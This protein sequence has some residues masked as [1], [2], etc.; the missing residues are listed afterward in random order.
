MAL[1]GNDSA[2]D[3]VIFLGAPE[4][5]VAVAEAVGALSASVGIERV[6]T[7]EQ[8]ERA[9]R[10]GMENMLLLSAGT[11]VVV[12]GY[13]LDRFAAGAVNFHPGSPGYPGRDPHHFAAY[14]QCGV[15]GATAHIMTER[16]DEGPILDVEEETVE[17][18][19]GPDAYLA[20]GNR[21][22]TRL[23]GRVIP[24]LVAGTVRTTPEFGWR[25]SKTT[26]RDFLALCRLD[27]LFDAQENVRR[28]RAVE[29]PGYANAHLDVA[30]Y[31]F[32]IE[33]PAP[34]RALTFQ[35]FE[36]DFTES[37]Y[38]DLLDQVTEQYRCIDF[39][40][41]WTAKKPCVLWRHDIDFSV[42][43][44][45]RL[46]RMEAERGLKATYFVMLGSR[47]Y[48]VF[49][50]TPLHLVREIILD[51]HHIGLHF[52]PSVLGD[53]A[54]S[55]ST[56]EERIVWEAGILERL[57]GEPVATVS[58]HNPD[59]TLSWLTLDRL[60]GMINT[61]GAALHERYSYVS[62]SNGIWRHRRLKDVVGQ[63]APPY[64]HVLTHPAWW[65]PEPMPARTRIRRTAEG[66]AQRTMQAYDEE[67]VRYGRPNVQ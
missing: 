9:T 64:L 3:L 52:D 34:P 25:G 14:D 66:R 48:N 29:M 1:T 59:P 7:Q 62:D 51:G 60:G 55:Q 16:V 57:T 67:L 12:P 38:G 37:A 39:S 36:E 61:Y 11:G 42:H 28:I 10:P 13:V 50:A 5:A 18:G 56:V 15:Y 47:F 21:C 32:R 65:V 30:G 63:D 19:A 49:E 58:I 6:V 54:S 53:E 40:T 20:I 45:R 23:I 35:H 2:I 22:V 43:R 24:Q 46:A 27:P 41:A 26:R 4:F 44:A 31:R 8:L 33:G 17:P